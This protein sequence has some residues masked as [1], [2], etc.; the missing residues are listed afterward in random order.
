M[1]NFVQ[2]VQG[3]VRGSVQGLTPCCAWRVQGVQA[4]PLRD[5]CVIKIKSII[6]KKHSR[7]YNTLHTLHTLHTPRIAI[8]AVVQGIFHTP[9][10]LHN[11]IILILK[12][13]KKKEE[14][15]IC[16]PDNIKEFKQAANKRVPGF[17]DLA[18]DLYK[19]GM[20]VGLRGA[21][22]SPINDQPKKMATADEIK[23][24]LLKCGQ[25]QFYNKD[26]VGD[27]SGIGECEKNIQNRLPINP[28]TDACA[29]IEVI[30]E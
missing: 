6:I 23:E 28:R 20:I 12:K 19:A 4:K 25:C 29:L 15:I 16:G 22:I 17:L 1:I 27:G 14:E 10:T 8:H 26:I 5:A 7:V 3:S 2:G 21:T 18:R 11:S 13:M 30:N 9:H 24:P